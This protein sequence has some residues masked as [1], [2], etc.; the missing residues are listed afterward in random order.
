LNANSSSGVTGLNLEFSLLN[1]KK[2]KQ[3]IAMIIKSLGI[4]FMELKDMGLILNKFGGD[5]P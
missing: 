1:A 2:S 5:A 3:P 4:G